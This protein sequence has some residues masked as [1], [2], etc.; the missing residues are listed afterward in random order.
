VTASAPRSDVKPV[1]RRITVLH[2]ITDLNGV[3][4]AETA[5]YNLLRYMDHDRFAS[6]VIVLR[7]KGT[8]GTIGDQ[9]E[10]LGVPVH[11]LGLRRAELGFR[12]LVALARTIRAIEP[13]IVQTWL[14]HPDVIGGIVARLCGVRPVIWNL[15][16][17]PPRKGE[18]RATTYWVFRLGRILSGSIPYRIV[19]CSERAL[20]EHVAAGFSARKMVLI[21]N[22]FDAGRYRPDPQA[23]LSVRTELGVASNALLVG[24]VARF[25]A[26][27]DHATFVRS[28]GLLARSGDGFVARHDVH[29]VLCGQGVDPG[30]R[31]LA[32]WIDET[33]LTE[34]FHLLGRRTDMP[35]L[36]ASLDIAALSSVSEAFPN[37]VGEAMSCGVPCAVTDVGDCGRIVGDTGGVVPPGNPAALAAAIVELLAIGE[38][39]RRQLGARA[40]ARVCELFPLESVVAQYEGLYASL[41]ESRAQRDAPQ[42]DA[43]A[44]IAAPVVR[45]VTAPSTL[46]GVARG[47]RRARD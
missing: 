32:E 37:V 18:A 30:N 5:L 35:R 7:T 22:G 45:S 20:T 43:A 41:C 16:S 19:C 10:K 2:L 34:R 27:K 8:E 31:T 33:G 6:E 4:G 44:D 28:A 39:G 21:R 47:T 1:G 36:M 26:D 15:R 14:Y 40:R 12:S 3:G 29:F 42:A 24:L 23:R 38:A 11:E 25:H 9:I 13:D 46:P 17:S